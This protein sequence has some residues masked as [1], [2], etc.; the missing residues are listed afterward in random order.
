MSEWHREHPELAGTWADPWM[1]HE[2]YRKAAVGA[3][4]DFDVESEFPEPPAEEG[5]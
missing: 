5:S 4:R 3:Y 2:S 1:Q